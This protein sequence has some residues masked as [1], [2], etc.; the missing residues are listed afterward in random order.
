MGSIQCW[1]HPAISAAVVWI[2]FKNVMAREIGDTPFVF[3]TTP[4]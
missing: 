4:Q 2:K 3:L 1:I